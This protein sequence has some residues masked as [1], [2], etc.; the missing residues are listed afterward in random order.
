MNL[1][2]IGLKLK[3]ENNRTNLNR[4]VRELEKFQ[5]TIEDNVYSLFAHIKV[6]NKDLFFINPYVIYSGNNVEQLRKISDTYFFRN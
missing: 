5:V 4:L 1:K 6:R 2:E 3:I